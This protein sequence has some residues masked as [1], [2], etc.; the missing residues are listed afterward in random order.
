M[1]IVVS[2]TA[3]SGA[4]KTL[5]QVINKKNALPILEEFHL[6]VS[7]KNLTITASDSE[8]WMQQTVELLESD[9]DGKFCC[10]AQKLKDS[11]VGII[12]QPV[13]LDAQVENSTIKVNH[14]TGST[15][16]PITSPLA[17]EYPMPAQIEFKQEA[18]IID[19]TEVINAVSRCL[20]NISS[21]E[22]RPIMCG[23][24]FDFD[25]DGLAI[26]GSDGLS[27]TSTEVFVGLDFKDSFI[28]P[29]KA[30]KI[31]SKLP[32]GIELQIS[33]NTQWVDIEAGAIKLRAR[34]IDGLY[35]KWRKV[36]PEM[37][38]CVYQAK[39]DRYALI[40]ILHKVVP[41]ALQA[42]KSANIALDFKDEIKDR[43]QVKGEDFDLAQGADDTMY[44]DEQEGDPLVIGLSGNRLI[45]LLKSVNDSYVKMYFF[46]PTNA[47]IIK[48]ADPDDEAPEITMLVMPVLLND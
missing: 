45:H 5:S 24:C 37:H 23:M 42:D 30:A 19:S 10:S 46:G 16:F 43:I 3:L 21:D 18:R 41:F 33:F 12:E 22:L 14:A 28:L 44:I 31:L 47:V 15:Y 4:V 26:V 8:I 48:E 13:T 34:Q 9:S 20:W 11:L 6:E 40:N 36:I 25:G 17:D 39:L 29:K 38:E 1:K 35:P 32:K 2:S 7:G 27:I